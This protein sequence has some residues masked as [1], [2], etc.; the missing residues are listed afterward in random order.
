[1][2]TL[3]LSLPFGH[4]GSGF[5]H[6]AARLAARWRHAQRLRETRRYLTQ[7]DERMLQDIGVS[8][9]QAVFELDR[10]PRWQG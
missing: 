3:S 4:F 6:F 1:M 7:M 10:A 8:R 5:G 2:T 9:A